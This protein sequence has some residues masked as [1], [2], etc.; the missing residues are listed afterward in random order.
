MRS[1]LP[2]KDVFILLHTFRFGWLTFSLRI[3]EVFLLSV[4]SGVAFENTNALL[5]TDFS[6][7][8]DVLWCGSFL[9]IGLVLIG[10]LQLVDSFPSV[11]FLL[12]FIC[13]FWNLSGS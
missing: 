1:Y 4:T 12:C 6:F 9:L 5:L 13:S 7:L 3:W 11:F 10:P 2:G 8:D